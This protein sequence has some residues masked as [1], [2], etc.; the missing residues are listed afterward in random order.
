M[1]SSPVPDPLQLWRDAVSKLEGNVNSLVAGSMESQEAVRSM[2]QFRTVSLGL[3]QAFEKAIGGYLE[4]VNLPSRKDIAELAATLQRV[5][6]KLD[7][8]L[9]AEA[10]AEAAAVPRP[11]RTR[12]SPTAE[13]AQESS[14]ADNATAA[15]T[16][17]L[18]RGAQRGEG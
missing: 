17:K 15:V 4:K 13:A 5:E 8:L 10:A 6:G 9:P 2:H 3:E 1:A 16:K 11:P 12:R 7:R 14:T 18:R